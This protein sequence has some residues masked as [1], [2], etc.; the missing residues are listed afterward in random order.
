LENYSK[1]AIV[2]SKTTLSGQMLAI[3]LIALCRIGEFIS[4][5]NLHFPQ[6][7][8]EKIITLAP[9]ETWNLH[10][11]PKT[12]KNYNNDPSSET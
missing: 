5:L 11:P 10:F 4:S 3:F 8:N 12:L 6:K 9:F 1:V 2:L 7:N